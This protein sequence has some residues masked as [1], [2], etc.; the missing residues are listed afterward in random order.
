MILNKPFNTNAAFSGG[1]GI[2]LEYYDV[3]KPIY[4]YAILKMIIT[5]TSYGIPLKIISSMSL[6][7]LIEWY[8]K[9]RNRNPLISL[10]YGHILN[11]DDLDKLL[12]K[13]TDD[14][15]S[16]YSLAPTLNARRLL[17]SYKNQHM[18]FPIYIYTRE[19]DKHVLDDIKRCFI[20]L[21]TKYFYGDIEKVIKKCDKNF[22][23]ILSD[24]EL[25][26]DLTILL[27][28]SWSHILL[29]REY[30]YNYK[31]NCKTFKYNL[32]ELAELYPFARIG[33]TVSIDLFKLFAAC[34]ETV[35]GKVI[36]NIKQD[37]G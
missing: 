23:Y 18:N 10:D 33:T 8:I 22:T 37:G 28:G 15:P 26:K 17:S 29:S 27:S 4:L 2:F 32:K 11:K 9:R 35:S 12:K 5:N 19:Y 34:S 7:S 16:I 3:I 14:D 1:A 20:G 31:D 13:I 21:P 24:I 6:F 36:D 25:L 30:S